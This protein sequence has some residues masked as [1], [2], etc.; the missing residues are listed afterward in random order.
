[1]L[2]PGRPG[3]GKTSVVRSL[4]ARATVLAGACDDLLTPRTLGHCATPPAAVRPGWPVCWTTAV[5]Q[6]LGVTGRRDAV[7]AVAT[8]GIDATGATP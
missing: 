1:V 5:L 4:G 2:S 3:I 6:N 8:F 7:A